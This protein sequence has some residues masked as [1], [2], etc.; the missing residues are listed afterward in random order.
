VRCGRLRGR[1]WLGP[2][3]WIR[4]AGKFIL[5]RFTKQLENKK[6]KSCVLIRILPSRISR[7]C[8]RSCS[9][10]LRPWHRRASSAKATS[11]GT[12]CRARDRLVQARSEN[13]NSAVDVDRTTRPPSP[14]FGFLGSDR[15]LVAFS[16]I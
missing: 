5:R 4:H 3:H 2:R 16:Y 1:A 13:H 12:T 8:K 6:R 11:H 7:N 15:G 14:S 10:L 9:K